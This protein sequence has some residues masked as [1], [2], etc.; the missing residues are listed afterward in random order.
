MQTILNFV[1]FQIG[2]FAT[3]LGAA[4]GM[5]WAGPLVTAAIVAIHLFAV[6]RPRAELTLIL[7]SGL[8]GAVLDSLLVVLGLVAYPAGM[9]IDNMAPYWIVTMWMLFAT[10]LNLSLAWLKPHKLIGT[11]FGLIGG[12]LAY[13]TGAK[14]GGIELLDFNGAMIA[15]ALVWGSVVPLLLVLAERFD[16]VSGDLRGSGALAAGRS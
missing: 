15:L 14:L 9:V 1:F 7:I 6:Q 2:W 12:P 3:V 16:G 11:A 5:P 4:N 8:I 10:T 13:Y